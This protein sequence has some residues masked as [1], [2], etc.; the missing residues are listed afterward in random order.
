VAA[1]NQQEAYKVLKKAAELNRNTLPPGTLV[2][3]SVVRLYS[4]FL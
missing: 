2:N 3:S 1:G 4:Y